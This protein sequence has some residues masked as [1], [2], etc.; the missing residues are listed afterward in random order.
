M[1]P[2]HRAADGYHLQIVE[3]LLSKGAEVD[4]RDRVSTYTN[5]MY[6]IIVIIQ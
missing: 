6:Y 3:C 4:S 1:T 5:V 2:L